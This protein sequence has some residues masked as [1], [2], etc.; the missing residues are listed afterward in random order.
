MMFEDR[1]LA[2]YCGDQPYVFLS[3][4]HRNAEAAAE[5]IRQ[6]KQDGF[7]IWYDEG[8]VPGTEWDETIARS[9]ANCSFFIALMSEDYLSSTNCRDE[10]N[11]ARDKNKPRLLVYL[12]EVQL[13]A[14]MEMRMGRNLA[15]HRY[16][17]KNAEAFYEK[18]YDAEGIAICLG[19]PQC[20]AA[21]ADLRTDEAPAV[22][23]SACRSSGEYGSQCRDGIGRKEP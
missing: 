5:V 2:P 4:S 8:I 11:Y 9:I 20:G 22:G 10:L 12:E 21:A 6:M 17:Y 7:W 18:L 14:G 23:L 13:P 15:I 3:Y 19:T 1:D 16:L